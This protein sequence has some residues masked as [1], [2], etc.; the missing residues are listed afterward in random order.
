[1]PVGK[2]TICP[3]WNLCTVNPKAA[4]AA[5]GWRRRHWLA[6]MTI[7]KKTRNR[8]GTKPM[9]VLCYRRLHEAAQ[10]LRTRQRGR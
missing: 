3:R 6:A 8:Q 2:S 7:A 1:M 10:V 5:V 9:N 4:A